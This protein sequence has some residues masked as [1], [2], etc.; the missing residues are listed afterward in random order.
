MTKQLRRLIQRHPSVKRAV[1]RVWYRG[2]ARYCPVCRSH[3]RKFLDFGLVPRPDARCPVCNALE[4]H[5]M[6]WI[7]V[8]QTNL[9][10]SSPRTM[11]HIA[12]EAMLEQIFRTI[13]N[14]RYVTADL[15]ADN[16]AVHIDLTAIP[17]PKQTFDIIHCSHVLEHIPDDRQAMAELYRVLKPGGWALIDVPLTA[18]ATF[19]DPSVTDPRERERL[20]GQHDHVRCYGMD[21]VDRLTDVGF[22]VQTITLSDLLDAHESRRMGIPQSSFFVCTRS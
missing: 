6:V 10:D 20:F 14:L 7:Y 12:P 11:L 16:V 15:M 9:F 8:Q 18:G 2:N 13:P 17:Y 1:A 21:I 5:R 22:S 19:E 3:L 4:R